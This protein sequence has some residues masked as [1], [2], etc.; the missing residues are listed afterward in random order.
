MRKALAKRTSSLDDDQLRP[1]YHFDYS[2]SRPNRFARTGI[3][4]VTTVV[5]D[6]DVASVFRTSKAVNTALRAL[7]GAS[8]TGPRSDATVR[9]ATKRIRLPGGALPRRSRARR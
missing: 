1:E 8:S 7:L 2:K 4:E 5:L 3:R 6:E 9:R